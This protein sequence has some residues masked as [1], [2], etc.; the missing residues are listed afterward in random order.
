M[1]KLSNVLV[2]CLAVVLWAPLLSLT[3]LRV[4]R[5]ILQQNWHRFWD[6]KS[7]KADFLESH[8]ASVKRSAVILTTKHFGVFESE[9]KNSDV[10][11]VRCFRIPLYIRK[12]DRSGEMITLCFVKY[13][14][15]SVYTSAWCGF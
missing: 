8:D 15:L 3:I 11:S 7:T 12:S 13:R 10:E 2:N 1:R 9:T 6:S 14:L 5:P 4:T